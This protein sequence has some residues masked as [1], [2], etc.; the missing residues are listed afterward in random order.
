MSAFPGFQPPTEN[1]SRL[2]NEIIDQLPEIRSIAELKVILYILRHTWGYGDSEK[3]ISIEE[4]CTG[5]VRADGSRI[6]AGCGIS[7][8]SV[9]SGLDAAVE[10]GFIS[11]L[12][13]DSDLAR[14]KKYYA[15]REIGGGDF[16][17]R[18]T[19]VQKLNP[20]PQKVNSGV[21]EL[22]A[23]VQ[24]L[25]PGIPKVE[26]RTK[27]ETIERNL[28]KKTSSGSEDTSG[29]RQV[30]ASDENIGK[31]FDFW[32]QNMPGTMTEYIKEQ[33]LDLIKD[34]GLFEVHYATEQAISM[35]KRFIKYVAGICKRRASGTEEETNGSYR[36]GNHKGNG[37]STAAAVSAKPGQERFASLLD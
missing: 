22:S 35:N 14:I 4:F 21:Q 26:P 23:G 15:I 9:R 7:A 33:L 27:K 34:Y 11:V 24:L 37:K 36:N 32:I 2:P 28:E 29:N 10:H 13:D 16:L 17:N 19:G 1:W 5:R 25:N 12:V 6:D 8:N 31:F 3:R 30:A 18:K 20:T